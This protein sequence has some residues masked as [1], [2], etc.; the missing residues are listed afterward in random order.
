MPKG[1]LAKR[2]ESKAAAVFMCDGIKVIVTTPALELDD[3]LRFTYNGKRHM[4]EI[5]TEGIRS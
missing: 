2:L 4:G 5:D 1:M 3:E